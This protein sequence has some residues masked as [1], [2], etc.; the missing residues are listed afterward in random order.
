MTHSQTL[1]IT[2]PYLELIYSGFKKT[3]YR[4]NIP[5]Y[6][7]ALCPTPDV[8]FFHYRKGLYLCCYIED[9]KKIK[10]PKDLAQSAFIT[11]DK[12]YAIDIKS[13]VLLDRKGYLIKKSGMTS[14]KEFLN[15]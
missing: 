15:G 10:R 7:R 5:Y 11:T 1:T 3:E 9:I 6:D 12:C 14:H 2:Q 13:S 4:K 8:I